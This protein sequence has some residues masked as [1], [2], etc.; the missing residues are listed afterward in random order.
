M[1]VPMMMGVNLGLA[2]AFAGAGLLLLSALWWT[3]AS[4]GIELPRSRWPALLKLMATAGWGLWIGGLVVQVLAHFSQV[5]VARWP[6]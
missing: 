4:D 6:H 5:G 3:I 2:A 1:G